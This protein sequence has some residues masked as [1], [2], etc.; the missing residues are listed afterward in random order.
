M[1]SYLSK[2][3]KEIQANQEHQRGQKHKFSKSD[4]F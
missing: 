3:N 4:F 1:F 2:L